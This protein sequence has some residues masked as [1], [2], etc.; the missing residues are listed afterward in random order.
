MHPPT[1]SITL[2]NIQPLL[3]LQTVLLLG[4]AAAAAHGLL[5]VVTQRVY[6]WHFDAGSEQL[7]HGRSAVALSLTMTV[8]LV[9]LPPIYSGL[10]HIQ[11][12]P[13]RYLAASCLVIPCSVFGHI[14]L[15][16]AG[17][18]KFVGVRNLI[19]PLSSPPSRLRAF[20]SELVYATTHFSSIVLV[21]RTVVASGSPWARQTV[22]PTVVSAGVWLFAISFFI[23]VRF[24]YSV[25]DKSGITTR[26]LLNAL[27]LVLTLEGGMLM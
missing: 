19:S 2:R 27:M 15:Y 22:L 9:L 1:W 5:W 12:L 18:L 13:S 26:G 10:T 16:G 21:Y 25:D 7:P 6:D 23:L 8:P 17:P 3:R 14:F 4:V 11:L 24:P 20:L